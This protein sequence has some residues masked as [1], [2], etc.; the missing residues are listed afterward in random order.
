VFYVSEK[1][2]VYTE[3]KSLP[4]RKDEHLARS[5]PSDAPNPG[6]ATSDAATHGL[7]KSGTQSTF[8]SDL[9]VPMI[10]KSGTQSTFNPDLSE[11]ASSEPASS[12]PAS[13]EP[14]SSET[15]LADFIAKLFENF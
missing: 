5:N 3:P 1:N 6:S 15:Q 9:E 14:A 8:N 13:S 12:E 11:P 7:P 4:S 2:K 10:P